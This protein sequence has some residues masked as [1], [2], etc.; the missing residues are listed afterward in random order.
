MNEFDQLASAL[1]TIA[2]SAVLRVE[3]MPHVSQQ[4][5]VKTRQRE[6]ARALISCSAPPSSSAGNPLAKTRFRNL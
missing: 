6:P 5:H 2:F 4:R 1:L 3:R